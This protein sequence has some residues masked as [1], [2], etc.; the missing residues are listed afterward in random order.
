ML[1]WEFPPYISGGLGTAC[2]GLTKAMDKLGIKVTFVLPR[3]DITHSAGSVKMLGTEE[4]EA[5]MPGRF[6][7]VR[8][9]MISSTLRPYATAGSHR[10]QI[11]SRASKQKAVQYGLSPFNISISI[12]DN[13]DG[14]MFSSVARYAE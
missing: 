4:F 14:D 8:F 12:P 3:A 1:G 10:E 13:Y 6:T 2:Y 11:S 9:R 7:N 5:I